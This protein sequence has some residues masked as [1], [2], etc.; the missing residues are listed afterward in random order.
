MGHARLKYPVKV[1]VAYLTDVKMICEKSS[2]SKPRFAWLISVMPHVPN[3]RFL[4]NL[5]SALSCYWTKYKQI[6]KRSQEMRSC[7]S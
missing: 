7:L 3:V 1:E 4:I 5:F 2:T 6:T